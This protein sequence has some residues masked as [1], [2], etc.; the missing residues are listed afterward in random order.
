MISKERK[1]QY[2]IS[3]ITLSDIIRSKLFQMV[4]NLA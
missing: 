2:Y 4:D 1:L 3:K